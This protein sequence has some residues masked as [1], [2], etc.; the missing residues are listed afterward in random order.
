MKHHGLGGTG[1]ASDLAVAGVRGGTEEE[2]SPEGAQMKRCTSH[3][4]LHNKSPQNVTAENKSICFSQ[5]LRLRDPGMASGGFLWCKVSP[6]TTATLLAGGCGIIW[7]HHRG[8]VCF[9]IHPHG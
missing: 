9:H 1:T 2:L 8:G 4:L 3:P 5:F 7:W 6:G